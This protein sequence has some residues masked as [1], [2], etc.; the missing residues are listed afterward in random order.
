MPTFESSGPVSVTIS[1]VLGDVRITASDRA[2]T[3]VD[4]RPGNSSA[5]SERMVEQTRVDFVD[6]RLSVRTPKHLGMW[7]GR[8]GR[9]AVDIDVPAGSRLEGDASMGE[10]YVDG[11]L[12]ECQYKTGFGAIRVARTAR[13]R[14]DT[15]AGDVIVD[16]AAGDVDVTTG[17]GRLRLGRIE[18][19]AVLKTSNG[20]TWVGE[21]TGAVRVNAANGEISVDRAAVGVTAKTAH[22]GVRVGEAVSGSVVLETAAGRIEVGIPAGTAAWL[23]LNAGS[24]TVRNMLD[25]A[26]GPAESDKTVEVR[27]RTNYGDIIIHRS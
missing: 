9:I 19:T 8:P 7:F 13:L 3:V 15:G 11:E 27:A 20:D 17:T 14:L 25:S 22:G 26:P 6:G 5:K 21:V 16:E 1:I 18:G 12:G 2:D 23:D 24:G 4:V 10:L